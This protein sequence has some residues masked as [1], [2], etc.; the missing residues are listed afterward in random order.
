MLLRLRVAIAALLFGACA[1]DTAPPRT[2]PPAPVESDSARS[3]WVRA[4]LR[5]GHTLV[6]ERIASY[7]H[8]SWWTD[9]SAEVTLALFDG[10]RFV[11][12]PGDRSIALISFADIAKMASIS[13]AAPSYRD[14]LRAAGIVI[15][16]PP[17]AGTALVANGNES[18]H[19]DENGYGNYAWD[20]VRAGADGAHFVGDGADNSDYL[21]WDNAVTLPSAG[22]VVEVVRD[23]PDN[24]PGDFATDRPSNLIGVH[25]GGAFSLYLLHFRQGSIP[26]WIQ[27]G[28]VL[29]AGTYVGRVGNSG[30]SLE[31]HLH[32]TML[33]YDAIS[34]RSWSV[35]SEW[36]G[37]YSASV[38]QGPAAHEE[39]TVPRT[40]S[41][42]SAAPF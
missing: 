1:T 23:R 7:D 29:P 12:Y 3:P 8:R 15:A 33:W 6:G 30:A 16:R 38:A 5:D 41:W 40:G 9:P 32:L 14:Q 10:R 42:I 18:Y 27:P 20:L 2:E 39:Y 25:L 4:T 19:L 13:P 31:P 36:Q 11:P 22:Y 26:D 21:V 24:R 37:I 28:V 34:R 35:P 17:L